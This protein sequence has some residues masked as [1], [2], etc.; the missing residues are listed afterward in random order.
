MTLN[1]NEFIRKFLLHTS[2]SRFHHVHHY[3]LISNTGCKKNLVK[4][5][6]LLNVVEVIL[7]T[8][9]LVEENSFKQEPA[10]VCPECG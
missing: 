5:R 6:Q 8:K 4:D 7:E 10:F 3:G 1:N 9:D 2:P